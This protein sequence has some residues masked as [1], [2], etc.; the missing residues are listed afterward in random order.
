MDDGSA[1]STSGGYTIVISH[2]EDRNELFKAFALPCSFNKQTELVTFSDPCQSR[3]HD[4]IHAKHTPRRSTLVGVVKGGNPNRVLFFRGKPIM[5]AQLIIMS[6]FTITPVT[7][8][9]NTNTEMP[10]STRIGH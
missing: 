7:K 9:N 6:K 4:H 2:S 8:T 5:F 3:E 1:L 10:M